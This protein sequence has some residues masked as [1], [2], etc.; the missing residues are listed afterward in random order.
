MTA[1]ACIAPN[2]KYCTDCGKV[3]LRRAEICP[4]C[5]CRQMG[6]SASFPLPSGPANTGTVMTLVIGNILWNG[7]GNL[8]IGDQRGW[9]WGFINWI[10]IMASL[11]TLGIPCILG[12]IYF[13]IKGHEFIKARQAAQ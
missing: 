13:S 12:V 5:G 10:L 6:A 7:L 9:K 3:I 4:G 1:S 2:E 11:P 8:L